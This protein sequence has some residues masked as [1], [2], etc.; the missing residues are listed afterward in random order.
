MYNTLYTGTWCTSLVSRA[1]LFLK[2]PTNNVSIDF[3]ATLQVNP[4]TAYRM[5]RDFIPLSKDDCII[6]NGANSGVG[7]AVIQLANAWGIKTIN[8]IRSRYD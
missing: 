7:Q 8:I 3:A 5:L 1:D 2:L 4:P 6:Q